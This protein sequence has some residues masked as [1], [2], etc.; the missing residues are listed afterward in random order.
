MLG[1]RSQYDS[2]EFRKLPFAQPASRRGEWWQTSWRLEFEG[3]A[4]PL[5]CSLPIP[6]T[7]LGHLSAII[8]L[9]YGD[10]R[11]VGIEVLH[12]QEVLSDEVLAYVAVMVL[13]MQRVFGAA[14]VD[15]V[16][17]HPLLRMV[18]LP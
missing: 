12:E 3:I 18:R 1:D 14:L 2:I 16:P 4:G 7:E 9:T 6:P 17:N 5:Q 10:T 8:G 15:G 13:T 11:Q